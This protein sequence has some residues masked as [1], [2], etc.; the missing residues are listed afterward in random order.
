MKSQALVS[1][2]L[3]LLLIA[4]CKKDDTAKTETLEDYLRRENLLTQVTSDPRGFYYKIVTPGTGANPVATSRVTVLYAGKLTNGTVFDQS[5][6]NPVT[7]TLNQL[8]LGWQYGLPLIKAGGRI[9]LYLP[10]QLGYGSQGAG[11]I[12]PN[13]NLVFDITLEAVR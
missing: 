13:S 3:F 8:I 11:T 2:S 5:G 1:L 6:P 9:L 4:G 12:P 7:F 10:P